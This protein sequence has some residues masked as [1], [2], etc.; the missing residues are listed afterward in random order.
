MLTKT[1]Q[2][3]EKLFQQQSV[4][5]TAFNPFRKEILQQLCEKHQLKVAPTGKRQQDSPIKAD[6]IVALLLE[7]GVSVCCG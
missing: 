7:I 4:P 1:L 3:A 5:K 6:Y 2:D